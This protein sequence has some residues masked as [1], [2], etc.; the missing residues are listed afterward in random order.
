VP[1]TPSALCY[2]R[3]D[4]IH[5]RVK[6]LA[7]ADRVPVLVAVVRDLLDGAPDCCEE[8]DRAWRDLVAARQ[9]QDERVEAMA[10]EVLR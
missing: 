2:A 10:A 1:G 3:A 6:A 9:Q 7:E 8:L 5:T 4:E